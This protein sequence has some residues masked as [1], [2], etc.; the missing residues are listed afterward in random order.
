M[1][2]YLAL[3]ELVIIAGLVWFVGRRESQHAATLV[4]LMQAQDAERQL[5]LNRI[6]RPEI[7]PVGRPR[8]S[9]SAEPDPSDLAQ[10]RKVGTV[11]PLRDTPAA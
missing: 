7:L 11:A 8:T 9:E 5:L 6:Q 3:C 2:F 4:E 1:T 10:Y